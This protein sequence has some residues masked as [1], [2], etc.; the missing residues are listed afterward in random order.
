MSQCPRWWATCSESADR[1]WLSLV[2]SLWGSATSFRNV[3]T[4]VA[5]PLHNVLG[6]GRSPQH[7][8][9]HM[10]T[11]R[12]QQQNHGEDFLSRFLYYVTC[13]LLSY[14]QCLASPFMIPD[15]TVSQQTRWRSYVNSRVVNIKLDRG[16]TNAVLWEVAPCAF[17]INRYFG[18]MCRLHLQGGRNNAR[19]EKC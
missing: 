14:Y 8:S 9:T 12:T 11:W 18:G 4:P 13:N 1:I 3:W 7:V 6:R 19:E 2:W 15:C 5:I 17:I 16:V 10:L